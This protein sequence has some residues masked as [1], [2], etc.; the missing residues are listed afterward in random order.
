MRLWTFKGAKMAYRDKLTAMLTSA[1]PAMAFACSAAPDAPGDPHGTGAVPNGVSGSSFA[2]TGGGRGGFGS[3]GVGSGGAPALGGSSGTSP[4]GGAGA[5]GGQANAGASG[6]DARGGGANAGTAGTAGRGGGGAGGTG[7]TDAGGAGA[8]AGT[9]GAALG[10]SCESLPPV[11]DYA[12]KGPFA[13]AKMFTSTGPNGNYTV[14][15]PDGS[16]GQGGFRHPI[17]AWGN[18]ITTTPD[19]YEETLTLIATHG[20]VI[21][22]CN[23]TQVER[24]CMSDGMDW[25]IEQN[26]SGPMMGKLDISREA[27]I[28][29]SW[30][31]GCAIDAADRAN[32][33]ATVSL[34]GMPPRGT[35]AFAKMHAPLLLFTS[36]GDTFVNAD[37][38]VTPNY[39]AS[40][41]QTFYA[42]LGDATAGHLYVVDEG[43][44][45]CLGAVLGL[46]VC[47]SAAVERAPTIAWLRLW[48]CGDQNAKKFFFGDDCTL[49]QNPWTMPQRKAWQ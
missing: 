33:K 29:Y 20:F 27:T 42:T 48:T 21:V 8:S 49:C 43:A 23:D 30:G 11:T 10:T 14:F 24:P 1:V 4:S 6:A 5:R 39:Q 40:M 38:Y 45:V 12:A 13:D 15:R 37:E 16:L 22:A 32:V 9:A 44:P 25:L 18:G 35:D 17:A 19:Q 7:G 26:A 31:G 34:H 28:G 2:G 47:G 46:G 41:V 3:G 36:T